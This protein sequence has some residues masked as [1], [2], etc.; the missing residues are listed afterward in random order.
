MLST[1]LLL[2]SP[3]TLL[4]NYYPYSLIYKRNFQINL[5]LY[6]VRKNMIQNWIAYG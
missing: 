1:T 2:L 4:F 5:K 3:Q 6:S